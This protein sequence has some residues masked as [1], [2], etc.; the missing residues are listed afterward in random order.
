MLAMLVVLAAIILM[1]LLFTN[2][3]RYTKF[4][5]GVEWLISTIKYALYGTGVVAILVAIWM[6]CS[7][8][9]AVGDGVG[10][11]PEWIAYGIGGYIGLSVL[12]WGAEKVVARAAN[13]HAQY[14]ESKAV[15]EEPTAP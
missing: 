9:V 13:M 4:F 3:E 15:V 5:E 10:F 11:K 12:G 2:I 1:T 8:A 14:V 6:V 7:V